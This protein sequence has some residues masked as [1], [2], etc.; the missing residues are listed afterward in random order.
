MNDLSSRL[1]NFSINVLKQTKELPNLTEYNVIRNQLVK[2]VTS[3]GANYEEAQA[4]TSK[5]DF[6]S[7]VKISLR[8]ARE[9]N[10]WL[11]HLIELSNNQ[12]KKHIFCILF[13]EADEL[14]KILGTIALKTKK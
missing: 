2:S 3:I 12:D 1:F 6:H 9:S 5:A 10:F 4:A 8:E 14:V 7:K 13:K 11:K